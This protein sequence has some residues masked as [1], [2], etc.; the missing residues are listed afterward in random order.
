MPTSFP[1]HLECNLF[2][3]GLRDEAKEVRPSAR[4]QARKN[5]EAYSFE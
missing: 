1:P 2:H 3:H 5:E 4:P